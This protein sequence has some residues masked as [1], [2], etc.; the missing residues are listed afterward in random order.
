DHA[1]CVGSRSS[2]DRAGSARRVAPGAGDRLHHRDEHD[3]QPAPQGLA[4]PGQG[5]QGL[6]LHGDGEPRGI[7]RAPDGPSAGR[8]W[9][10]R[11]GAESFRRP[12]RRAGLRRAQR[13]GAA[14]CRPA[15]GRSAARM[16][17]ALLAGGYAAAVAWWL[18]ILLAR[19]TAVGI[20]A[21]LGLVAWVTAM[22]SVLTCAMAA[23]RFLV[24]AAIA[25]W[26]WLA[27][28]VCRSVTG[29]ECA[30]AVYRGAVFELALSVAA[31]IAATTAATLAWRYGLVVR[32]ARRQTRAHSEAARITGRGLSAADTAVVLDN[33]RPAAYCM[34]GRPGT[35]VL[36]TGAIA[37]LDAA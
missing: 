29:Q 9:R 23:V 5:R 30:A 24:D 14:A 16:S 15:I 3:G 21:R 1:P 35:I 12:D 6:S 11:G 19:L 10:H 18:P 28:A 26:P 25:H 31:V 33:P 20:S 17:A 36:T 32:R 7:Q 4:R 37:V 22:A 13:R 27:E 2:G 8:W 34:P